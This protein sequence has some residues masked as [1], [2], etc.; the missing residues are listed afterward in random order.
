VIVKIQVSQYTTAGQQQMFI[1]SKDESV[2]YQ[3][4]ITEA[5]ETIMQGRPKIYCEVKTYGDT[6]ELIDVVEDQDW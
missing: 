2:K 3:G 6:I 1:Y 4:P 5:V